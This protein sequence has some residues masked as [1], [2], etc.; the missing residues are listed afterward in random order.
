MCDIRLIIK[1]DTSYN[2]SALMYKTSIDHPDAYYLDIA[3][4]HIQQSVEYA[5]K[6]FLEFTGVTVPRTHDIDVLVKMTKNN[7]SS[8]IITDWLERHASELTSWEAE[9]RYNMGFYTVREQVGE[10]LVK[11][12]EFLNING[13]C[14]KLLPE[15]TPEVQNILTKRIPLS[16]KPRSNMK[17]N[18]LYM[19]FRKKFGLLIEKTSI[20]FDMERYFKQM[21]I[22]DKESEIRRLKSVYETD[23][24]NY[25]KLQLKKILGW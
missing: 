16:D 12:K 6:G 8:C 15:L 19:L 2:A 21:N 13:I 17:W 10:A 24:M 23:D 18:V 14:P 22:T 20:D 1:A 25:I 11:V 7:G 5:L 4:F 9:S 3:C